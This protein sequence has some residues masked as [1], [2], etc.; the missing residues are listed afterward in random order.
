V[1]AGVVKLVPVVCLPS[2]VAVCSTCRQDFEGD[3]WFYYMLRREGEGKRAWPVCIGCA[4][5]LACD[6]ENFPVTE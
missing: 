3:T 2:S 5:Q 1:E 6:P 4:A